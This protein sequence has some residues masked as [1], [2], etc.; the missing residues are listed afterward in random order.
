M[1]KTNEEKMVSALE[2]IAYL[3][4]DLNHIRNGEYEPPKGASLDRKRNIATP[5]DLYHGL[6]SIIGLLERQNEMI[7]NLGKVFCE[8]QD[9]WTNDYWDQLNR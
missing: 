6:S 1:A 5:D 7:Y 9:G 4:G 8:A 3:L 2:E